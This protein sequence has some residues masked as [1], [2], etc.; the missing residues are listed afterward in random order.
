MGRRGWS[1][2]FLNVRFLL[3]AFILL[4]L[5]HSPVTAQNNVGIGTTTPDP[6]AILDL[7]SSDKGFLVPRLTTI[8]MNSVPSPASGLLI[9]NTTVSG[10]YYYNGVAWLPFLAPNNGWLLTG[11][12]GTSAESNYLGTSDG[13]ALAIRTNA[14]QRMIVLSTGEVGIGVSLPTS[15]LAVGDG[16]LTLT[17]TTNTSSELRYYEPSAS[18]TNYTGFKAGVMGGDILYTLPTTAP[19][20][21]QV[22]TAGAT[23]TTLEW[24]TVAGAAADTLWFVGAGTSSLVGRGNNNSGAGNYSIAAGQNNI[25]SGLNSVVIGGLG[26]VANGQYSAVGGGNQNQASGNYS[27]IPG[28]S[29]NFASNLYASVGGGNANNASGQYSRIGGGQSNFSTGNYSVVGGGVG[30][31]A[32]VNA[33]HGAIS[34]GQSNIADAQWTSVTGGLGNAAN[35]N[36]STILGGSANSA[37]ATYNVLAGFTTSTG[38]NAHYSMVFGANASV[39]QSNT[40]VFNHSGSVA[41]TYGLTRVGIR[42]NAPAEALDITGNLRFSNALMPAG[43]A[44]TAGQLL[45]SAGPGAAPTWSSGSGLFWSLTGNGSTN[46]SNN[47]VGTTDAVDLVFRTNN[48]ERVRLDASGN[49][50]PQPRF[51]SMRLAAVVQIIR[52]SRH[53]RKQQI[54]PTPFQILLG[55]LT[56][57]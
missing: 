7:T 14:T 53:G 22:L 30:N 41:A 52:S 2:S 29:G 47:F 35:G 8:E 51:D 37:G 31:N 49:L 18:G 36:Y 54:L 16:N 45:T 48:L 17:N 20:A 4:V 38:S 12:A 24:S 28:G 27:T 11:N 39:T 40:I 15:R 19:T 43:S 32:T 42:N 57:F 44:G 46:A 23:P 21:G 5:L 3:R 6:S 25:A 10:F 56:M 55:V 13:N 26:S 34:G 50:S 33:L 9:Y 1:G